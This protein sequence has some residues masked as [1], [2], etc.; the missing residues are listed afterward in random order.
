MILD[1]YNHSRI[2]DKCELGDR[3]L[4]RSSTVR[5][6]QRFFF[7]EFDPCIIVS[8]DNQVNQVVGCRDKETRSI[9][10]ASLCRAIGPSDTRTSSTY[11]S[12]P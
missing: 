2:Q 10:F 12:N 1:I 7:Y 11:T 3:Q 6:S 4:H 5:N 9:V 8:Y